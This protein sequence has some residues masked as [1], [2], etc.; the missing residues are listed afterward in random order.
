VQP[1]E[2]TL[3]FLQAR[4]DVDLVLVLTSQGPKYVLKKQTS[5]CRRLN[6][7]LYYDHEVANLLLGLMLK[8][9]GKVQPVFH[10]LAMLFVSRGCPCAYLGVRRRVTQ[11]QLLDEV[12]SLPAVAALHT[13]LVTQC[14]CHGEW[15]ILSHDATFKCLFSII[16]QQRMAQVVGE[17]HA[18]HTF[19]GK[20]GALPGLSLQPTE[21]NTYFKCAAQEVLPE[22]ARSITKWI[23]SDSPESVG[24]ATDVFPALQGVAED[25]VHLV[26]RVEACFGEKRTALSR[27]VLLLQRKF[28]APMP[29][30]IYNGG[31]P[32]PEE[33][34]IWDFPKRKRLQKPT[35]EKWDTYCKKPYK[36]HQ[37]YI[38][39]LIET[40]HRF[41]DEMRRKDCKGRT[42]LEILKAGAAY[43]HFAYLRN[44]SHIR[45]TLSPADSSLLAWGTCGNEALHAQINST[46]STVIQQHAERFPTKLKAFT[47]GKLLAHNAAAYSPTLAQRSQPELLCVLQGCVMAGFYDSFG[48]PADQPVTS[49]P[50]LRAPVHPLNKS[51]AA[52][53]QAV[54]RSQNERWKKQQ[55]IDQAKRSSRKHKVLVS[56]VTK[57]RTV[58]TKKKQRKIRKAQE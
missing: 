49:I 53:T 33:E 41:P 14:T 12:L 39:D 51:K 47:L 1:D 58:F 35:E 4:N 29:S 42:V 43:K 15:E 55:S 54:A 13:R 6:Q 50:E 56:R 24:D 20:T 32:P 37:E 44:G 27:E 9:R 3:S 5:N 52:R 19:L 18:L 22:A 16:G 26:I 48:A 34:G 46:Q 36:R 7:N 40:A 45:S 8:H 25:A 57:K 2:M 31:P 10:E 23:F 21:G 11:D 30:Q 28:S 17:Y 38:D